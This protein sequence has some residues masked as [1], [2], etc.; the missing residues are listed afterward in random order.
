VIEQKLAG[1]KAQ[2]E[3]A[4][5]RSK[6]PT[7]PPAANTKLPSPICAAKFPSTATNLWM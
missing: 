4:Q 3:K 2:L 6:R 7:K 1:T 5:A